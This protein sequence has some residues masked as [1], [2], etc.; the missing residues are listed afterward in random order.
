[1][2]VILSGKSVLNRIR[3]SNRFRLSPTRPFCSSSSHNNKPTTINNSNSNG[4]SSSSLSRYDEQYRALSNLDFMTAAK[5]LFTDPPKK[6]QF[7]LD[8]HLVQLFFVCLPSLAVYLVAQYARSEMKKMDAELE[9]K[10]QTEFEAQAKEMEL[11]AAEEKAAKASNPELLEVKERLDKLEVTVKEIMVESKNQP[12]NALKKHVQI[13]P[14]NTPK[15][16]VKASGPA[17]VVNASQDN[18]KHGQDGKTS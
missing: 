12:S 16:F 8:F 18:Q 2:R 13:D 15:G 6:K 3:V 7:G 14:N 5:I 1:M 10:K 9:R 4:S 17:P 11:K